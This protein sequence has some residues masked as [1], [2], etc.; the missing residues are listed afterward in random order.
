MKIEKT[1][2]EGLII[3]YPDIFN[4]ERGYFFESYNKEKFESIG[5]KEQFAQD[6]QS[7]SKKGV[8]RC[9]HFQ[10]P[11]FGQGKLVKVVKGKVLDVAADLRK[12]SKTYGKWFSIILSEENNK[13]FWIP[14]GFAHGFLVL[15]EDTILQYKL[16]NI[17]NKESETGII[18][19]DLDLDIDWQLE[20]YGIEEVIIS[21][22]DKKLPT[23][24]EIKG[25]LMF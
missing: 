15:E 4:D 22:K 9:L 2:I 1:D 18:W 20:E 17:Y 7:F 6:S 3:I 19:D 11:P 12:N 13:M 5:I 25:K 10:N 23:L 16:T 21:D 24:A 14:E 8:L